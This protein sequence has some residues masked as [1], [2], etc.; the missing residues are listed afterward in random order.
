MEARRRYPTDLSDAE[1]RI[2][3]PLVPA[4]APNGRPVAYPRRAIVNALLYLARAGCSWRM[5][6]HDFPPHALVF[7]YFKRWR[8]DGTWERIHDQLRGQVRRAAGRHTQPS[9]AILDSQS[10]KMVDQP[11]TRGYDGGKLVTG[12][13]RHVLVDTLGL[14]LLVGVTAA[15][16]GD[17]AGAQVGV[18][19]AKPHLPRLH[20]IGADGGYTG[21]ALRAWV[22]AHGGWVLEIVAHLAPVKRFVVLPKRWIVER[23]LGWLNRYRRLSKDY[24]RLTASSETWIQLA[25]IN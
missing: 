24:E 23:T 3:A 22:A 18:A 7:Y 21:A 25:M 9:A 14:L 13:K 19:R 4:P 11:G 20:K 17:R 12:R 2:L 15:S 5:L 10:V 16:V 1:W 8:L 6:P